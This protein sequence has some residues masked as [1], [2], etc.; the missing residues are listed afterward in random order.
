MQTH[1]Q[2]RARLLARLYAARAADPANGW[3]TEHALRDAE[4]DVDFALSVLVE[5][6]HVRRDG[7]RYRIAGSGVLAHEAQEGAA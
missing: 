6:G 1:A 3:L 7:Y 4:G 2:L 5:V